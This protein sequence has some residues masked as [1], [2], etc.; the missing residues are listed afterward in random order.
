MEDPPPK[1]PPMAWPI[2]EPTATPLLFR[3]RGYSV[4]EGALKYSS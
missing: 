4:S 1:K 3:V 2:D